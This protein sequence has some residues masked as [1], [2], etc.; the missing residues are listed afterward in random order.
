MDEPRQVADEII[1]KI[2]TLYN[3]LYDNIVNKYNYIS[4]TNINEIE[5]YI[6]N[7]CAKKFDLDVDFLSNSIS[8]IDEKQIIKH[9]RDIYKI[10]NINFKTVRKVPITIQTENF[11]ITISRYFLSPK[12]SHD[13]QRL[14]DREGLHGIYPLD[15][16]LGLNKLPHHLTVKAMLKVSKI[17]IE[18]RS[19]MDASEKLAEYHHMSL[20][21]VT[22]MAVT[23]HI[24]QIA[25]TNEMNRAEETFKIFD[26]ESSNY[27]YPET[28]R[29][30]ILYI[31]MDGA[32]LNT[33]DKKENNKSNW[34]ENKLGLVFS[35]NS[36]KMVKKRK[37]QPENP[38]A[39]SIIPERKRYHLTAKEYT[40]YI[41]SVDTFKKLMFDC[42]VRNGYGS[43]KVT[44][45]VSDGAP[46]IRNLKDEIFW[47][48]QQILDYFHLCEKIS[49]FGKTYFKVPIIHDKHCHYDKLNNLNNK[50][51]IKYSNF[52]SWLEETCQKLLQSCYNDVLNDIIIKEKSKHVNNAKLSTYI[53]NNIN[54]I[55]YA[56]YIKKGY[57]IGSGAIESA[58]KTV[59]KER[60]VGPG[61]RWY[62]NSA[63]QVV[64]LKAK[65]ESNKW[66][67]EVVSPVNRYYNV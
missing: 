31:E 56:A 57:D 7:F 34:H 53:Q 65:L 13:A 25:F 54:N 37:K 33:R 32:F 6:N 26:K 42:A 52:R 21:P 58:N 59:L 28:Q 61:M 17:A 66:F 51:S 39:A 3:C 55:D 47:D 29:D 12:T 2:N 20:D 22:I 35:S 15:I 38:V 24:G 67:E 9:I 16:A 1:Y 44:V 46:W 10:I 50:D 41:G 43:Y 4:F 45:L 27:K 40:A 49:D 5:D 11:P 48:A 18:S 64:T 23:N 36:K 62:L 63:Q 8:N 30:G 19:F 14:K 60:L